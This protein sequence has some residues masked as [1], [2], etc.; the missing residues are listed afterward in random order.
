MKHLLHLPRR[1]QWAVPAAI[2]AA[3]G[4]LLAVV[5]S[6]WIAVVQLT[7]ADARP[8]VG[9]TSDNSALSLALGYNGLGRLDGSETG[10]IGGGGGGNGG[11]SA[12]GGSTG[13]TRLFG[14]EFGG[15]SPA[16]RA[17]ANIRPNARSVAS[18]APAT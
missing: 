14:S 15:S 2:I 5:S 3:A 1:A 6:A 12:F 9:S 4:G 18:I 10:S 7:P 16:A 11:G 13:I 8:Y 17:S